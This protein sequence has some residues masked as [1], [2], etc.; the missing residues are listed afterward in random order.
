MVISLDR[1]IGK[2]K[3]IDFV[4]DNHLLLPAEYVYMIRSH[5]HISESQASQIVLTDEFGLKPKD[6]HEFMSKQAGGINIVGY[7]RQD[8]RNLLRTKRNHS[9]R[10]GEVGALLIHFKKQ[11]ENPSFFYEFQRDV[12]EQIT[13]IFWADAHMI[14][15]YG[16]AITYI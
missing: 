1:K 5:Q 3:V 10:Y 7:T 6:F 14:N 4:A 15:D 11:S 9:L 16:Y 2:Y 13:N 12:E 8:H